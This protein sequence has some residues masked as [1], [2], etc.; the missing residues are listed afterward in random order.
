MSLI[1][2]KINEC[3]LLLFFWDPN[4]VAVIA[5]L[6]TSGALYQQV[7]DCPS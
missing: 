1:A 5:A 2:P 7:I 6:V 4:V 3:W